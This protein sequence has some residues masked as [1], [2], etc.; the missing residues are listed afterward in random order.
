MLKAQGPHA[1]CGAKDYVVDG[2]MT[3]GFAVLAYPVEYGASGVMSFLVTP[4]DT[5]L[6]KDLGGSTAETAEAIKALDPDPARRR[7]K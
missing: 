4:H 1:H 2:R 6:E 7:V 5:V 3:G